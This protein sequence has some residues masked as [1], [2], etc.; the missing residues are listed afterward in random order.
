MV[1]LVVGCAT[2]QSR[3][4]EIES[5]NTIAANEE[6]LKKYPKGDLADTARLRIES[7]WFEKAE[8]KNTVAAYEE[9]LEKYP[10]GKF[11]DEARSRLEETQ[12]F[13]KA[14]AKNTIAA[15]EEF[16]GQYPKGNYTEKAK[17]KISE[18]RISVSMYPTQIP[19]GE[20]R[21][22]IFEGEKLDAIQAIEITPPEGIFVKE[23]NEVKLLN[24]KQKDGNKIWVV[25]FF[26]EEDAQ[27]TQRS[28]V[29]VTPNGPTKQKSIEIVNHLPKI[30]DLKILS[31]KYGTDVEFT[32]NVFDEAENLGSNPAIYAT[33]TCGLIGTIKPSRVIS[34]IGPTT[35]RAI[36]TETFTLD[37]GN[38]DGGSGYSFRI[39]KAAKV[40]KKDAKNSIVQSIIF[41]KSARASGACRLNVLIEDENGYRSNELEAVVDF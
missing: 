17:Q 11:T 8:S 21:E 28:V 38:K 14:E 23:I 33:V 5:E 12:Y 2:M 1:I 39:V 37:V 3:W 18:L 26:V 34:I 25:L 27:L 32:I 29:L 7:L 9:F 16:L 13:K 20:T 41:L 31:A 4:R 10:E 6:F 19:Q 36:D 24:A 35:L 22:I 15:Y 40:I 30:S